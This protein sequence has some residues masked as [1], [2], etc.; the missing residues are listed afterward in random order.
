MPVSSTFLT[1]SLP[2]TFLRAGGQG[3]CR[4]RARI[5]RKDDRCLGYTEMDAQ[6]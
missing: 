2:V 1:D 4:E 5:S 3:V 6:S